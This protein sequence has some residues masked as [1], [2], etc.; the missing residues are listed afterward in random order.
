MALDKSIR[1]RAANKKKNI[2]VGVTYIELRR[3]ENYM[4][5]PTL[6]LDRKP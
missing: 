3:Y 6:A 4:S 1:N 5:R 2:Q